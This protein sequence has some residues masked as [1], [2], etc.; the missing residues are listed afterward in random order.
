MTKTITKQS[1][2]NF[3]LDAELAPLVEGWLELNPGFTSS[4]L[5]NLALRN[6][7]TQPFQT[8]PVTVEYLSKKDAKVFALEMME[9]HADAMERLK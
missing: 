6:F 1:S 5:G 8:Q 9:E 7:V 3:R 4:Q 2:I